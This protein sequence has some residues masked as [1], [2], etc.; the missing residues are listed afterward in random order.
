MEYLYFVRNEA[1]PNLIKIGY[2][3]RDFIERINELSNTSVPFK[4]ELL[5][6]F[7]V[8]DGKNCESKIHEALAAHRVKENR[9]F[10]DISTSEALVL[11]AGILGSFVDSRELEKANEFDW[12]DEWI[13]DWLC[14]GNHGQK[15]PT[16]ISRELSV[17]I[18]EVISRLHKLSQKGLIKEHNSEEP[19]WAIWTILHPGREYALKRKKEFEQN[20]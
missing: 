5:A 18:Q 8:S 20:S 7:Q 14:F 4:F 12:I 1:M 2:T 11:S 15:N 3:G 16:Y 13:I 19:E 17:E 6:L 9:E 10:F